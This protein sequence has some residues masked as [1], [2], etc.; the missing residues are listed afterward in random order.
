MS[1]SHQ[2]PPD[3]N[4]RQL[5]NQA[6][7]LCRACRA[8]DPNAIRRIGQTHPSFSALTP[9]EIAA[10][11][12]VLAD[13]QLVIARELGFDSWPK[14]K[15][16][17]ES[18]SQSATS[19]HEPVTEDNMQ[20]M[21]AA[22]AKDPGLVNQLNESGLPP[23]YTAALYRN[24]KAIDFLLEHGAVVDIFAYAY[25]GKPADAEVLLKRNPELARATTSNGMT[26]LHYAALAGHL[27]VIEVLL[28]YHANVNALDN[29][30]RTAL[31]EACHAGPWKSA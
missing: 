4:L 29:H 19:M 3:A 12:I 25:L 17:L 2:L 18:L 31:M 15:K 24:Q 21:R 30:G 13:A 6:K 26:A 11:G 10:V 7:D 14:L 9:A 20:A 22:V 5:R 16:H 23:L 27:D 1:L 8:G 28:R